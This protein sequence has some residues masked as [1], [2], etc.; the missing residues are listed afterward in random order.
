MM[1][2]SGDFYATTH[3]DGDYSMGTIYE[4]TPSG[5]TWNYKQL[6]EFPSSGSDGYY[7]YSSLVA[8]SHGN[9]YGTASVGGA[10]GSGVVFQLVP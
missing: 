6:F 9:L 2:S 8:D 1:T 3:C 10:Y 5:S 7:V 4:L